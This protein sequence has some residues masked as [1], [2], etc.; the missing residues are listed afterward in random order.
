MG[1]RGIPGRTVRRA[2]IG[3][4]RCRFRVPVASEIVSSLRD[5]RH[6]RRDAPCHTDVE[7][8]ARR[9]CRI[10]CCRARPAKAVEGVVRR[11]M[12]R[13]VAPRAPAEPPRPVGSAGA[14]GRQ[15]VQRAGTGASCPRFDSSA[16]FSFPR[17]GRESRVGFRLTCLLVRL[18]SPRAR[19]IGRST[20]GCRI[21]SAPAPWHGSPW[22]DG[23]LGW[24]RRGG[25]WHPAGDRRPRPGR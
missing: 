5:P 7:I 10:A 22:R 13:G 15:P 23:P 19:R 6:R 1:N 24:R 21:V 18:R 20:P 3:H 11:G 4:V 2:G 14:D 12:H 8:R 17:P 16:P 9:T 25:P